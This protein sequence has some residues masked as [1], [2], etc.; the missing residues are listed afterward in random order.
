MGEPFGVFSSHEREMLKHLLA[1]TISA[2]LAYGAIA[3]NAA[4]LRAH[5]PISSRFPLFSRLQVHR[6]PAAQPPTQQFA[7]P[8]L[9]SPLPLATPEPGGDQD[10][11]H[12][13]GMMHRAQLNLLV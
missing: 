6:F 4:F 1:L 13:D 12:G 2:I 8:P 10:Y 3:A 7:G 5:A 11:H 9:R